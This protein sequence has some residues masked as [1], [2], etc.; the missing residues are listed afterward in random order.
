[1][2]PFH[3]TSGLIRVIGL[4]TAVIVLATGATYALLQSAP[5]LLKG[6]S[7]QTAVASL[8]VSQNGSNYSSSVDGYIFSNLIPGGLPMPTSGYSI[9]VKNV[10]TTPLA[11]K[12]SVKP[13]IGNPQNV[14]LSKVYL[15]LTPSPSG[16]I[17]KISFQ[18]LI[19]ADSTGGLDV[20]QAGHIIPSQVLSFVMRVSMDLDAISGPSA[21]L[22][23][24]D[25]NFGAE[26]VN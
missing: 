18:D 16:T 1:M 15:Q 14:D 6:N 26:A 20:T 24:I 22:S 21:T 8:Q 11:L 25:F 23:N 2:K 12:L 7:V 9:F 19:A 10:G 17:Q 5:G 13:T 3:T 4:I